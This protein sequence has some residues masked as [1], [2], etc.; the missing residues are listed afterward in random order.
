MQIELREKSRERLLSRLCVELGFCLPPEAHDKLLDDP[1]SDL[2]GFVT[3]VFVGEGLDP[4]MADL[5]L[6]RQVRDMIVA[7]YHDENPENG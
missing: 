6:K 7:A 2:D 4:E 3:A 1:P 5:H